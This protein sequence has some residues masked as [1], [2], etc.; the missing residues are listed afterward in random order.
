MILS[1]LVLRGL[2]GQTGLL[3]AKHKAI[4]SESELANLR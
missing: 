2:K 1:Y 3:G 4:P